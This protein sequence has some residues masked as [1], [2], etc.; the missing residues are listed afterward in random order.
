MPFVVWT[1][2]LGK[3]RYLHGTKADLKLGDLLEVGR[4]SNYGERAI[5]RF[6]Y[7]TK[8][9]DAATWGAELAM[10]E[11]RGRIYVVE[12]TGPFED[13]PDLTDKKFPGNPTRS[14]RSAYP[15]RITGELVEWCNHSPEQLRAM[16]DGIARSSAATRRP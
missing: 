12:P 7:F 8:T 9:L 4:P 2:E 10:G 1:D 16:K 14:Y 5:S 13:D 3:E 6:I 11:G 15:L